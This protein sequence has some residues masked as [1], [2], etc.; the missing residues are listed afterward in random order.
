MGLPNL[1][2]MWFRKFR[3]LAV[4]HLG[5]RISGTLDM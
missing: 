1:G 3:V 2:V 4:Q 5:L